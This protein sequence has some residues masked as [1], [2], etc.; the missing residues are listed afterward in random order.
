MKKFSFLLVTFLLLLPHLGFAADPFDYKHLL[1]FTPPESDKSI[2]YLSSIF[3]VVGDVLHGTGSQIMGVMFKVFNSAVLALGGLIVAYTLFVSTLNTAHE[4][5]IMGKKWSSIWIPVR[6]SVGVALLLPKT[7]GYSFIQVMI[8][9]V[10]VQGVGMADSIWDAALNYFAKG[11][12][13]IQSSF[14]PSMSGQQTAKEN[15]QK[16][17]RT[18]VCKYSLQHALTKLRT[19]ELAKNPSAPSVP[20]FANTIDLSA[21]T[22]S[23]A[24]NQKNTMPVPNTQPEGDPDRYDQ[25]YQSFAGACGSISWTPMTNNN[26]YSNNTTDAYAAPRTIALQQVLLNF[27][28]PALAIVNNALSENPMAIGR[29]P[30]DAK[31]SQADWGD[32]GSEGGNGALLEGSLMQRAFADYTG[33]IS[34]SL[35]KKVG[36]EVNGWFKQ[37]QERGW[38]LAGAYYYDLTKLN[39]NASVQMDSSFPSVTMGPKLGALNPTASSYNN[40]RATFCAKSPFS[41]LKTHCNEFYDMLVSGSGDD[42]NDSRPLAR[43]LRDSMNNYV[44]PGTK[45]ADDYN[46]SVKGIQRDYKLGSGFSNALYALPGLGIIL[47]P[48]V[49]IA[50]AMAELTKAEKS[51]EN[52]LIIVSRL[53]HELINL[54][55]GMWLAGLVLAGAAGVIGAIP[56]VTISNMFVTAAIWL[57]PFLT[58]VM[59]MLFSAGAVL[60]YYVP[61]IPYLVFTFAGLGWFIGVIEAMVA[62]PIVAIGCTAS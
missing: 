48:M 2:Q 27:S 53:G 61:L 34:P 40:E 16:L 58:V 31:C 44:I 18:Q 26:V 13:I 30:S 43:F 15:L 32:G 9:W 7:T 60:A 12:L 46:S 5:E 56:S 20:L 23:V 45:N 52:P 47:A 39:N 4:G 28:S 6:S 37:A 19:E 50:L 51:N 35:K 14:Q 29:C 38:L 36:Q 11:G 49:K 24:T 59:S 54:V 21:F 25:F 55:T 57:V 3:G 22:S 10:V 33:I 8:M 17:M 42:S 62:A 1:D 41:Q